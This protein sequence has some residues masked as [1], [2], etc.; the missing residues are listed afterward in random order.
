MQIETLKTLF[1]RDLN[2]LKQLIH[3]GVEA[4]PVDN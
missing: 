3:T 2:K 1:N 4:I